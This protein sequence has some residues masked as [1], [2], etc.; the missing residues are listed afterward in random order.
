MNDADC[1]GK[2]S[3]ACGKDHYCDSA[4]NIYNEI[5]SEETN[6]PVCIYAHNGQA[7]TSVS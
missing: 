6:S 5:T 7:A 4:L 1:L 3:R 2:Q